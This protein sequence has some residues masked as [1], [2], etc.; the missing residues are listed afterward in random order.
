ML[1]YLH[2]GK[3]EY[4]ETAKR[5]AHYFIANLKGD[6][7]PPCDFRSPKEPVYKDS[8]AG[9]CAAC[10]LIEL[11]KIVPEFEQALYLEPAVK[12]LQ[13]ADK[14]YCNWSG[15]EDSI[16]QMGTEAYHYGEKNIPIIY[17]DFYFIEAILKLSGSTFLIW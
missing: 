15:S 16:V 12:M 7:I 4:L 11:S 6:M 14:E 13:S 8:T 1:S 17:G 10:G 5:I 3:Q 9:M 2:T